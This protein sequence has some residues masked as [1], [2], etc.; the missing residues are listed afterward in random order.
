MSTER[1]TWQFTCLDIP[2]VVLVEPP[3]FGDDRGWFSETY[4]SQMFQQQGINIDFVQDNSSFSAHRRTVRG[5]HYQSPP[6]A[7]DKLIR[8][9]QGRI[10][11]VA[12][13]ITRCSPTFGQHVAVELSS[14]NRK[15]LLVP[16]GFAHGFITLEPDTLVSY[17]VSSFYA[18]RHDYGIFWHDPDLEIDWGIHIDD[19]IISAKDSLAPRLKDADFLF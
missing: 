19:G 2:Q 10:L 18:P 14:D 11:D 9:L 4:N 16:V 12:V 3:V 8:V 1:K 13:D 15:Q 7:Q 5:L 17:K 6:F